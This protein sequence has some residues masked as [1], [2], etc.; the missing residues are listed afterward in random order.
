MFG[1][2]RVR[3]DDL[4]IRDYRTYRNKYCGLCDAIGKQ[5]GLIYR[6]IIR[7]DLVFFVLLL[8]SYETELKDTSFRCPMNP[9]HKIKVNISEQVYEYCAFVNYYLA[10]LKLE[11]DVMDVGGI[12]KKILLWIFKRNRQYK[13]MT[14]IYGDKLIALS[15]QMQQVNQLEKESTDFDELS[16]AWGHFFAS[17]FQLYFE[18]Y[19]AG[20]EID[21]MD[22]IYTLTFNLGKW[23]YFIDAYEDYPDDIK[24][25]QFNLLY[26]IMQDS[27]DEKKVHNKIA[28][29]N[30]IL[31]IKMS[32][33]FKQLPNNKYSDILQNII[34]YGCLDTYRHILHKKY[35]NIEKELYKHNH[36]TSGACTNHLDFI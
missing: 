16:N 33:A 11:D 10:V 9:L 14:K 28:M 22:A 32:N 26:Q 24:D 1:Y 31:I 35:P 36:C 13:K 4:K 18:H 12:I 7:Y 8:E 34:T 23:I 27:E 15:Q 2:V 19:K 21:T 25:G 20:Q 30:Q 29:I 17:L 6:S 5:Y 3:K